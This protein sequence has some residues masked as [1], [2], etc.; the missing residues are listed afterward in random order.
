MAH[1]VVRI[2]DN[3]ASQVLD[4]LRREARVSQPAKV[5]FRHFRTPHGLTALASALSPNGSLN[6]RASIAVADKKFAIVANMMN[7]MFEQHAYSLGVN[8]HSD[9]SARQMAR[10]LYIGGPRALGAKWNELLSAFVNLARVSIRN[11]NQR[12]SVESFFQRLEAA[13]WS[14][15]RRNVERVLI[16]LLETRDQANWLASALET[17]ELALPPLDPL[18]N[19]LSVSLQTCARY[20]PVRILHDRQ[21]LFTPGLI[22]SFFEGLEHRPALRRPIPRVNVTE[23]CMG[24]SNAHPS[25]Q[26]ADLMASAGRV[27]IEALLGR[28]NSEAS[29]LRESVIPHITAPWLLA[30]DGPL[31]S[32]QNVKR[33]G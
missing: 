33:S 13:R 6:Q 31:D 27:V 17:G 9:D 24:N 2:D 21:K 1:G 28:P 15:R 10:T 23:F 5:K 8:P 26:L 30:F 7:I 4:D 14:C 22:S 20:G 19:L 25:L 3:E 12:E 29:I 16:A 32:A 11:G 18:I